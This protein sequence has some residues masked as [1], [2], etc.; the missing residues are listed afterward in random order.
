MRFFLVVAF[1]LCSSL[2]FSDD[3]SKRYKTIGSPGEGV[4]LLLDAKTGLTWRS[5]EDEEG[6]FGWTPFP[7][8]IPGEEENVRFLF[9][10]DA[11][12]FWEEEE[13]EREKEREA[14]QE[15]LDALYEGKKQRR[16]ESSQ[17]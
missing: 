2:C 3:D 11:M 14:L 10:D 17:D 9:P 1:V 5:F 6:N 16:K 13:K 8:W 7:Y 4:V 15:K 12:D